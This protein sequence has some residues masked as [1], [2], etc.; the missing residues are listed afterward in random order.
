MIRIFAVS[1][2]P[3]GALDDVDVV[4][5]VDGVDGVVPGVADETAAVVPGS[6]GLVLGESA[7]AV[8]PVGVATGAVELLERTSKYIIIPTQMTIPASRA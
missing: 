2:G 4:D 8:P 1:L 5:D 3:D 6:A 7:I